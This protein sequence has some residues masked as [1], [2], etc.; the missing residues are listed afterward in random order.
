MFGANKEYKKVTPTAWYNLRRTVGQLGLI[1]ATTLMLAR[2][3]EPWFFKDTDNRIDDAAVIA[4]Y[5]AISEEYS[6]YPTVTPQK[7]KLVPEMPL[8]T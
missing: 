2:F 5:G 6:E 4:M 3:I 8:L 1:M 7:G